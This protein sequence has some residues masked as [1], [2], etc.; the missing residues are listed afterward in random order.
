MPLD[1]G[2]KH[3]DVTRKI[4]LTFQPKNLTTSGVNNVYW[5]S[6]PNYGIITFGHSSK[7]NNNFAIV[8]FRLPKDYKSGSDVTLNLYVA[9]GNT[10]N[11]NVI[12]YQIQPYY[13]VDGGTM[14]LIATYDATW[15]IVDNF[16]WN[17][18]KITISGT[19]LKK[20]TLLY[21]RL[22]M[23]DDNNSAITTLGSSDIVIEVDG[24][25]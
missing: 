13:G 22:E 16:S 5:S 20:D 7:T 15:S 17:H 11:P 1:F 9:C 14:T 25:D 8:W 18:Q 10:D 3:K 19:N 4:E 6:D 23:E 12:D 21:I 24:V 2:H